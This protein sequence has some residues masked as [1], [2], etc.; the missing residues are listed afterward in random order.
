MEKNLIPI[1]YERS[2]TQGKLKQN[3]FSPKEK[4]IKQGIDSDRSYN[5]SLSKT[6]KEIS[7][8]RNELK[9]NTELMRL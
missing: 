1:H 5:S 8:L 9:K 3:L 6:N 2:N 4:T 7:I